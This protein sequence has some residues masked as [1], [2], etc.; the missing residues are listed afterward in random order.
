LCPEE[1]DFPLLC[2]EDVRFEGFVLPKTA[3]KLVGGRLAPSRFPVV[4][5]RCVVCG[6]CVRVC[7]RGAMRL[8]G[9]RACVELGRCIR[10][11]C[12][13]EVCPERA[14]VLEEIA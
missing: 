13:Q 7:P 2:P 1:I 12:C 10:C 14:I 11:Y 5:E 9:G 6:D 4:G 3:E 8:V